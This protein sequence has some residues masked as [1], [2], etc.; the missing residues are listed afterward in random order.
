MRTNSNANSNLDA[1]AKKIIENVIAADKEKVLLVT[2]RKIYNAG[3]TVY[4]K[5]FLVDSIHN[6]LRSTP[7]KLYVDYVD[8]RDSVINRLLLNNTNFETY[9]RFVLSDSLHEDFYWIR[10]YTKEMVR[11]N[12]SDIAVLPFYVSNKN[13]ALKNNVAENIVGDAPGKPVLKFYP[14]GGSIISGLNSIVALSATDK[15]E[16][17]DNYFRNCKR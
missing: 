9:G 5:A 7:R 2:D 17:P 11:E 3:E 14:E 15:R 6:Y 4:F 1:I 16:I 13:E 8:K 12:I 10:A